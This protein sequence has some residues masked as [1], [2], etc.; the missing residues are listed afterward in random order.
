MGDTITLLLGRDGGVAAVSGGAP[1]GTLLYGVVTAIADAAY[2]DGAAAP[3]PPGPP[4]SAPPTGPPTAIPL[5][6]TI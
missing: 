2:D 1:E 5:T 6:E 4:P 3:I